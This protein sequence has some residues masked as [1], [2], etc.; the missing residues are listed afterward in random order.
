MGFFTQQQQ[1]KV[2]VIDA[3]NT[4]T[5]R[6]LTYGETQAV[7]ADATAFDVVAQDAQ[8]DIAKSQ[9]GK[10]E[11]AVVSWDGPGF[12]GQPVT[13]E[14]LRALPPE[15]GRVLTQAVEEFNQG[16]TEQEQKN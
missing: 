10:L 5:I 8:F 15:I 14:N 6:K 13:P 7:L 9:F 1:T 3:E 11:R 16:L 2:V 4:V 12:E